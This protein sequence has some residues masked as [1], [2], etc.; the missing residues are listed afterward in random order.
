MI[1]GE[2]LQR[3]I[4]LGADSLGVGTSGVEP[5]P[6]RWIDS[7]GDLALDF[8]REKVPFPWIGDRRRFYE[9][10]GVGMPR[11]VDNLG[12]GPIFHH[13]ARVHHSYR[14]GEVLRHRDIVSYQEVRE[15]EPLLEIQE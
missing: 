10:D 12:G 15:V 3:R 5:A 9:R 4:D 14:I 1:G 11:V 2:W 8:C 7:A 6:R 13:A